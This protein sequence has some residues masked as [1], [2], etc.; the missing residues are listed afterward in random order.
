MAVGR[1]PDMVKLG[2]GSRLSHSN[3]VDSGASRLGNSSICR[4]PN[5]RLSSFSWFW[6]RIAEEDCIFRP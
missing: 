1:G 2:L 4:Q 3:A 5:P 6:W